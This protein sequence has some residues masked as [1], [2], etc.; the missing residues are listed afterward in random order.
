MRLENWS[1]FKNDDINFCDSQDYPFRL[2]G[3]YTA[4]TRYLHDSYV[5][6]TEIVTVRDKGNYKEVVSKEGS[7]YK[8]Y[9][10]DV[11]PK[12]EERF[13][14]YYDRLSVGV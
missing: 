12:A 3:H 14:N 11:N 2:E 6:T 4:V 5:I 1:V 13:P 7:V 9:K 8:L 10:D